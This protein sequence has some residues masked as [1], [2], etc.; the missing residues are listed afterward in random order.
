[1][2]PTLGHDACP[3]AAQ[4]FFS[5]YRELFG[6][7]AGRYGICGYEAM[8]LALDAIARAGTLGRERAGVVEAAFATRDRDS[9]LGS[10]SI[11]RFGD[12]TLA[13]VGAYGIAESALLFDRVLRP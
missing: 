13:E 2:H 8:N 12:T 4:D 1:M 5:R 3:A 11:D 7:G 6:E 10:Y 9:V